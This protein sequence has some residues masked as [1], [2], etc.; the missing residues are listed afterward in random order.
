MVRNIVGVIVFACIAL[1]FAEDEEM[2]RMTRSFP[3][4]PMVRMFR[5]SEN[6]YPPRLLYP[7]LPASPIEREIADLIENLDNSQQSNRERRSPTSPILKR[8]A[9]RFKFCRIFDA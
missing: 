2:A 9:C 6:N 3:Y 8:Y 5:P 1:V 4:M 7:S